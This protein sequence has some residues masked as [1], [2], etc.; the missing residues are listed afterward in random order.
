MLLVAASWKR[1]EDE[2]Q[3]RLEARE[4]ALAA[5]AARLGRP[6]PRVAAPRRADVVARLAQVV[7]PAS[8]DREHDALD[9]HARRGERLGRPPHLVARR[10]HVLDQAGP[11]AAGRVPFDLRSRAVGLGL[12]AHHRDRQP[13]LERDRR[14]EQRGRALR[15]G[16]VVDAVGQ[17]LDDGPARARAAGRAA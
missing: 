17:Q 7:G 3:R 16:E 13:G 8:I 1:H 14:H 12:L 6:D 9:R 2:A 4:D 15:G 10:A 5:S 11:G